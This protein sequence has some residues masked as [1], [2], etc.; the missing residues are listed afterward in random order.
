MCN[1]LFVKCYVLGLIK[2]TKLLKF[3]KL[4]QPKVTSL[5]IIFLT[6]PES[7]GPKGRGKDLNS[8]ILN[9]SNL[10]SY[11]CKKTII[12][13]FFEQSYFYCL[14]NHYIKQLYITV[15]KIKQITNSKPIL[16]LCFFEGVLTS[17]ENFLHLFEN[18]RNFEPI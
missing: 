6:H 8:C 11:S 14:F 3:K 5:L 17:S 10:N 9:N 1:I 18:I 15:L 4:T 16:L 2:K 12:N 13:N 7:G